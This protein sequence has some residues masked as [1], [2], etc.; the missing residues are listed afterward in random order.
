MVCVRS[1]SMRDTEK[2][3]RDHGLLLRKCERCDA[4]AVRGEASDNA[5][6]GLRAVPRGMALALSVLYSLISNLS[7]RRDAPPPL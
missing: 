7:P 6:V 2:R 4:D 1:L 5:L 3:I